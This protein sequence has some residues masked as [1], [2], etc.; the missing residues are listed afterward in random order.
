[1]AGAVAADD[2]AVLRFHQDTPVGFDENRAKGM[3][4][5]RARAARNRD[6]MGGGRIRGLVPARLS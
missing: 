2:A 4:A 3:I 1:M 6:G 5:L